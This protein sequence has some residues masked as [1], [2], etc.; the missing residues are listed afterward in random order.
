[1]IEWIAKS[2][3]PR[4]IFADSS[5]FLVRSIFKVFSS[6]SNGTGGSTVSRIG[7]KSVKAART[8]QH[9]LY[10]GQRYVMKNR[11]TDRRQ[12][13][14]IEKFSTPDRER[15]EGKCLLQAAVLE[16]AHHCAPG[17]NSPFSI[18][19]WT[20]LIKEIIR[21][22]AERCGGDVSMCKRRNKAHVWDAANKDSIASLCESS[23]STASSL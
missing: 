11:N 9:T 21:C 12:N 1:M 22:L 14:E 4:A 20:W 16:I 15:A 6:Q 8:V 2:A 10:N 17:L 13:P 3:T 7:V 5:C 23:S 19:S 18:F